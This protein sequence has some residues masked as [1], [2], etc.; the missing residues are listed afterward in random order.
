L[1][2]H[3]ITFKNEP[4]ASA[5]GENS[6]SIDSEHAISCLSVQ[7]QSHQLSLLFKSTTTTVIVLR[8]LEIIKNLSSLTLLKIGCLVRREVTPGSPPL[9]FINQM[10]PTIHAVLSSAVKK[11]AKKKQPDFELR[12][13]KKLK[14]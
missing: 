12:A 9:L 7:Q 1:S 13:K 10:I 4:V 3:G 5:C 6:L 11:K 14:F 8:N 2:F